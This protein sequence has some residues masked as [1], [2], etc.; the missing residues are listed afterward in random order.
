MFYSKEET[1]PPYILTCTYIH[2]YCDHAEELLKECKT[3][4]LTIHVWLFPIQER[5]PQKAAGVLNT[6]AVVCNIYVG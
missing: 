3:S 4:K 1:Q 2:Y 6:A 5:K